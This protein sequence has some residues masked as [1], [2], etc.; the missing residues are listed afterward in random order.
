MRAIIPAAGRGKRLGTEVNDPPKVMR[1]C[2]GQPL[3][4]TVLSSLSF[5]NPEDIYIVVGYKK[6]QVMDYFGDAY[7]YAVQT[8]QLGTGHAVMMCE[9]D[10]RDYDGTVLVTFGDM[11]MFTREDLEAM[12]AQHEREGADCTLMTAENPELTM[13]ARIVRD[14]ATGRFASI[15]EGK[16]C[17]AEQEKIKELFAGVLVFNSRSLFTMLPE[18]RTNNVQKEYYLTEVP[19]LMVRAGMKVDTFHIEDGNC[20]R[21]VNTMEDMTVCEKLLTERF[22]KEGKKMNTLK[23]GFSRKNVNPKLGIGLAG[24]YLFRPAETILD[25]L[26]INLLALEAGG[27]TAILGAIDST[28]LHDEPAARV[29]AAIAEALSLPE[30]AVMI[31]ATH[32]HTAPYVGAAEQGADQ[33]AVDEY[34][35]FVV[36][37]FVAAAREAVADLRPATLS[38]AQGQVPD[39]AF[40]RRYMM[41]DGTVWTNPGLGNP[42]IVHSMGKADETLNLFRLD[43]EGADT[44]VLANFGNHPDTIGGNNI[45]ADWPGAFRRVFEKTI[46]GTRAI[47]I[48]GAQGE[49]NHI[50]PMNPAGYMNGM[51]MDF[52]DVPRGYAQA[53]HMGRAVA[54]VAMGLYDKMVSYDVDSLDYAFKAINLPTAMPTAEELP[55]AH[56]V[57][58]LHEAGRDADLPWKGMQLTTYVAQAQ[59][60]VDY[61]FGPETLP[62]NLS[63]LTLGDFAFVGIAGE[64]FSTIGITL[65]GIPG[66]RAVTTCALTNGYTGYFPMAN[67]YEEG[68]YEPLSSPFKKGVGELIVAEAEK[69]L[70]SLK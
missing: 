61:E 70:E 36:D 17:N 63:V 16:D 19:E 69:L 34:T 2:A 14:P 28:E 25:D 3:L 65:R 22:K 39:I 58:A 29:R 7:H 49:L 60:M 62:M 37:T 43:R 33:A 24:Y 13:W 27:K 21:G 68:G 1:R 54:G 8:E 64:P 45:S 59:R 51:I 11:P 9:P 42:D 32:T 38:F 46:E 66:F 40:V 6:E 20:L 44:L 23:A 30:E 57:V 26:E 56:R 10:F 5:L 47:F 55:E 41:K 52:D 12:C 50:N 67:A 18:I 35:D 48:N 31:A 53:I 4:E 15:V